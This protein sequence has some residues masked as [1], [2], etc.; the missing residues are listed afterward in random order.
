MLLQK[1]TSLRDIP[2]SVIKFPA[3]TKNG[4]AM[5]ETESRAVN[6]LCGIIASGTSSVNKAAI[7][8]APSE[9]DIGTPMISMQIMLP[10]KTIAVID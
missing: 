8:A 1:S 9:I 3:S 2:P 4:I 10:N 7:V 5:I 6:S